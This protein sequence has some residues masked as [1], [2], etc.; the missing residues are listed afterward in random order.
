LKTLNFLYLKKQVNEK[1]YL[2][3]T[4]IASGNQIEDETS[5]YNKLH[6]MGTEGVHINYNDTKGAGDG[7]FFKGNAFIQNGKNK[8]G[9]EVKAAMATAYLGYRMLDRKLSI[10]G[11][12][13]YLSGNDASDS[14]ADY[15]KYDHSFDLLYG[16]RFPYYGGYINQIII[17]DKHL[18]GGGLVNSYIKMKYKM[19]K[20]TSL[21][22]TLHNNR[23]ATN[24][25]AVN[26]PG[27]EYYDKDL[28]TN[29]DL[30]LTSA[31]KKDIQLKIGGSYALPSD[32]FTRMSNVTDSNGE[33]NSGDN[34][35]MWV[36]LTV[37]PTFF[38]N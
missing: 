27:N 14:S 2:S 3:L 21:M 18:K 34:Y 33:F 30:E 11:G 35:Y 12:V 29:I 16:A 13:D 19:S 5:P 38:K 37:K 28:G 23:L 26:D 22:A 32:S 15:I 31:I 10:G 20:K 36:M 7:L 6:F 17:N 24:V 8:S 25:V 4:A 9:K 1:L